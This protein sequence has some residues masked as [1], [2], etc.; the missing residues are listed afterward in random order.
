FSREEEHLLLAGELGDRKPDMGEE[1]A[2][3]DVYAL[4]SDELVGDADGIA[5]ARA[6]VTRDHLELLAEHAALG[7][8]VLDR[9]FPALL[10]RLEERWLRLLPA[11]LADL[12][13]ALREGERA[14]TNGARCG[15]AKELASAAH[16]V[17]HSMRFASRALISFVH[18]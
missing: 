13:R 3:D 6:V 17:L 16:A 2:G 5:W 18:K 4:A 8:D 12:G 11:A 10:I 14:E 1:R 15:Q 7:V 9:E